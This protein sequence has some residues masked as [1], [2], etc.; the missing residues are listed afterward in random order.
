MILL[1]F[2][3]ITGILGLYFY[4]AEWL[5]NRVIQRRIDGAGIEAELPM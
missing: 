4:G 5:V 2:W 3:I 1:W